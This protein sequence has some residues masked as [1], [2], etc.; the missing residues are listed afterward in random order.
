MKE[1]KVI[2]KLCSPYASPITIVKVLRLD[3]KQ[4]IRLYNNTIELNKVIIK[5]VGFLPNFKIIFDKLEEVIVYTI[6]DI[7]AGY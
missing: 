5:N 3:G 2:Q 7:V 1:I 4:K 6:M